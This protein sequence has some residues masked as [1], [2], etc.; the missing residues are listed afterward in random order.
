MN[1]SCLPQTPTAQTITT[2]PSASGW[3]AFDAV[4][5]SALLQYYGFQAQVLT[6]PSV[7]STTNQHLTLRQ[8]EIEETAS[9]SA[10]IKK[11][12]MLVYVYTD[13][14]PTAP[15]TNAVYNAS[16]VNLMCAP[17]AVDT[18][19]YARVSDTVCTATVNP[20]RYLRTGTTATATNIYVVVVVDQSVTY[21]ASAGIRARL[22]LENNTAL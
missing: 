21:A 15:A 4:S 10:N 19:N 1:M 11:A 6:F 13:T 18:A 8:I 14:A 2:A 5:T 16:T 9:S 17:I 3:V 7:A 20:N 22:T 12:K